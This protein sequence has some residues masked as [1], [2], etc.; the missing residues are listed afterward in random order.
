MDPL[1]W[2][3][4]PLPSYYFLFVVAASKYTKTTLLLHFCGIF[5]AQLSPHVYSEHYNL[6]MCAN[7]HE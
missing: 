7:R 3:V 5:L 6:D 2:L 1:L 4:K